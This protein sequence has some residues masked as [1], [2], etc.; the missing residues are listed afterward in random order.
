MPV[1]INLNCWIFN[2]MYWSSGAIIIFTSLLCRIFLSK[3]LPF[4]KWASTIIVTLGIVVVGLADIFGNPINKE[5]N[6]NLRSISYIKGSMYSL[7]KLITEY[8]P[9]S[10]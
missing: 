3:K 1:S 6:T 4:Y 9:V 5:D 10:Q 2:E 7:G 8:H